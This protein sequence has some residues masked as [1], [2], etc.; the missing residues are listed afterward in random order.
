MKNKTT[1]LTL[2]FVSL[3]LGVLIA[4]Q[5]RSAADVYNA[6]PD[7]RVTEMRAVLMETIT[8][9]QLLTR[10]L[11]EARDKL[12]QFEEMAM[13]GEGAL[14]LIEAELN[15]AR[16][17]A[18]LVDVSGPGLTVILTDSQAPA[19][20]GDNP[21][22]YIVHDEDLLK[23]VNVLAAAGAEAISINDQRLL[24]TSEIHCAGPTIS[25]NNIRVGAPFV[26]KAIGNPETMESAL[27]MRD[28]IVDT[29]NF[30][31]IGV[32]VKREANLVIPAYKRPLRFDY[33]RPEGGGK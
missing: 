22:V 29:L 27:R 21:N 2:S 28:G 14:E 10:E 23:L 4:V 19:M 25:I 6:V 33:A 9:N 30:Y 11:E 18:G 26:I 15:N 32:Q 24:A 20:P 31:G 1:Q 5:L 17:L 8:Q 12:R 7:L 3:L 16:M 13:R